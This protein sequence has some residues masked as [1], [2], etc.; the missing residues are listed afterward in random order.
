MLLVW[1]AKIYNGLSSVSLPQWVH[2]LRF[3]CTSSLESCL[4]Q[5]WASQVILLYLRKKVLP[6]VHLTNVDRSRE[7]SLDVPKDRIIHPRCCRSEFIKMNTTLCWKQQ[8]L[9]FE[10]YHVLKSLNYWNYWKTW[11]YWTLTWF[12]SVWGWRF[13]WRF[14][15]GWGL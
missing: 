1:S 7:T 6:K 2:S 4:M 12:T 14:E 15:C 13:E 11:K 9:S 8:R 10:N 5:R 3:V